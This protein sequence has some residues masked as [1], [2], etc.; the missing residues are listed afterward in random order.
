[1]KLAL[2]E[3]ILSQRGRGT[4]LKGGPGSIH[5]RGAACVET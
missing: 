2:E 1:V 5:V 4:S 3:D